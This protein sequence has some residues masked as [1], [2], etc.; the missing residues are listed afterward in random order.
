MKNLFT[1]DIKNYFPHWNKNKRDSSRGIII[2][3]GKKD[4]PL[5]QNDK[6]SLVFAKNQ[7]YYK[8]P[9]GGINA[10]EDKIEALIREVSEETGLTIIRESIKEFGKVTRYQKSTHTENTIF[11]QES[12]YYFAEVEN[13]THEQNL[14]SY[15]KDAGFELR[16]VTIKEAI[17]ANMQFKSKDS[18]DLLMIARDTSILQILIGNKPEPSKQFAHYLLNE[19]AIL[20]PGPWKSHSIEVA[21]GAEKI[22]KS[23][24]KNGG[25]LDSDKAY[26]YGLL[27][28]I[29]RRFGVTYLA[30]VIDGYDYLS[31][32][33][34]ENASRICI[35]HS[36][37]LKTIDD[38]IGKTDVSDSQ[39]KKIQNL[40]DSYEYD[41]YDKLIQLMD[42][43]C[44]ADGTKNLKKRM[45]DVKNR[46][47][48]YPQGKYDKNFELKSYFEKLMDKDL[49]SVLQ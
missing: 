16:T 49:Y 10:D 47:G 38:Y 5:S 29:G 33:G 11:E 40:L 30:H 20:N 48:Y 6:I 8:F 28:D 23:I 43:T 31:A 25:N 2:S 18:F 41:D 13:E 37:N 44:N 32:M 1:L 21:K 15:E 9:G 3:G 36:F 7:G 35:T 4:L 42:S 12:F 22:A 27:H 17:D 39:L 46:Y 26:I 14:D 34:F 19:S 45:E 24:V